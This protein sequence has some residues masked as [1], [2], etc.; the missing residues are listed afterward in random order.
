MSV[1]TS[2]SDEVAEAV[3]LASTSGH[4]ETCGEWFIWESFGRS[5]PS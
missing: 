2:G 4:R 5:S 3:V 1:V